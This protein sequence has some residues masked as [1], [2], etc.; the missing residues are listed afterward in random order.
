MELER[1][2]HAEFLERHKVF[3]DSLVK[4]L[5]DCIERDDVR[6]LSLHACYLGKC[7]EAALNLRLLFQQQEKERSGNA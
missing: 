2:R 3:Y 1:K 5:G 4:L 6:E 7:I